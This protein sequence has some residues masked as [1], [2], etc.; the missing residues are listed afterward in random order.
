MP[1]TASG[2]AL[3]YSAHNEVPECEV[4]ARHPIQQ[5]ICHQW[6]TKGINEECAGEDQ[7][8]GNRIEDYHHDHPPAETLGMTQSSILI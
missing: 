4:N 6:Q 2:R 5:P 8:T 1:P 3:F 7:G